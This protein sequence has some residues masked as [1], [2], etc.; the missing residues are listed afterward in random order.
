MNE[1]EKRMFQDG[2]AI[3]EVASLEIETLIRENETY[4]RFY[5]INPEEHKVL[6]NVSMSKILTQCM[7]LGLAIK[8][9]PG[10]LRVTANAIDIIVQNAEKSK[11]NDESI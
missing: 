1:R 2:Q 11:R 6:C 9:I 3:G 10:V 8:L 5:G 4:L 7:T